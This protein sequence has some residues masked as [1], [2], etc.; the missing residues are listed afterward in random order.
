[1]SVNQS[2][3]GD[4]LKCR[5]TRSREVAQSWSGVGEVA[6]GKLA[7]RLRR[8]SSRTDSNWQSIVPA[9]KSNLH[10]DEDLRFVRP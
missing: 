10:K 9:A 8:Q 6:V 4:A 3:G 5:Q 2:C 1:M 7:S